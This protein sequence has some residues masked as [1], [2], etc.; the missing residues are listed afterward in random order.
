MERD[1]KLAKA[2]HQPMTNCYKCIGSMVMRVPRL[3][4]TARTLICMKF[5]FKLS[6]TR[7]ALATV[8]QSSKCECCNYALEGIFAL[9]QLFLFVS[10]WAT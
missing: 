8:H 2:H 9:M 4:T 1:C 7:Q 10:K 3:G 6:V 5:K